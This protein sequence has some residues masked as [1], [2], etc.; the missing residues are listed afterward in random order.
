MGPSDR[1]REV[2]VGTKQQLLT[3]KPAMKMTSKHRKNMKPGHI[4]KP[5]MLGVASD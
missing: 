3:V 1:I 2:V 5:D 4:Q